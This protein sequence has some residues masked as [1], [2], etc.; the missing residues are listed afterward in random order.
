MRSAARVGLVGAGFISGQY[1][2]TIARSPDLRLVAVADADPAR[3]EA[4]AAASGARAVSVPAMMERDDVD[5]V[6]NL[7]IP[8]AHAAVTMAAV[9]AGIAV[10]TEKPLA[11]TFRVGEELLRAAEASGVR[12]GSA[13]DTVLGPGVQSARRALDDGAIGQPVAASAFWGAPGHELWH[14]APDFYYQQGGGPLLDMGPYYLT[15][16]I[17]LLG[18][19]TEV[20]GMVREDARARLIAVGPRAGEPVVVD[21]EV[22]T[23]TAA[24]LRH[25]SGAVSTV[26]MSF[27]VW[28]SGSPHIEVFGTCGALRVPDPNEFDRTAALYTAGDRTWREVARQASSYPVGRGMGLAEMM[29]AQTEGRPHR[30]SGALALHTLE[31]LE[32]VSA[33]SAQGGTV[34]LTTTAERPDPMPSHVI[35]GR[36]GAVSRSHSEC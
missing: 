22:A 2:D 28:A 27:D 26:V 9:E 14:P 16:L 15:A 32:A 33:A 30:A 13:P 17:T 25:A 31:V 7:T 34:R 5:V 12:I 4:A 8:S 1:L 29:A 23:H 10:Y 20:A 6:L 3:A 24:L 21:T 35:V 18:P 11:S 36:D 19:V